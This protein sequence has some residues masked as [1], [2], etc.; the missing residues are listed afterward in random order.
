MITRNALHDSL[1]M[2]SDRRVAV[3][4]GIV[5]VDIKHTVG[6][7]DVGSGKC[8][9]IPLL[10]AKMYS[11]CGSVGGMTSLTRSSEQRSAVAER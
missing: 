1:Y 5:W 10:N 9:R 7:V 11:K 2:S 3:Q 6:K 8:M 4:K